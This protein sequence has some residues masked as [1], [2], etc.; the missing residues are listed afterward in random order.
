V[1]S[2]TGKMAP[3]E[4][5]DATSA[6]TSA[7]RTPRDASQSFVGVHS[8][9]RAAI[10]ASEISAGLTTSQAALASEFGVGRTPLREAVRMLQREGLVTSQPNQRVRIAELSSEDVEELYIMRITLETVAIRVT[11]PVLTPRDLAELE[12][13]MAQM[14]HYGMTGDLPGYRVPHGAFHHRLVYAV[15]SRVAAEIAELSDH[16]ERYRQKYGGKWQ[17]RANEHRGI[18]DAAAAGEAD[19]AAELLAAHYLQTV[20]GV[21]KVMDPSH[22]L[23]RLRTVVSVVAP[24]AAKGL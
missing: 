6:D 10:L 17:D 12:G 11:V 13:F 4:G 20:R 2:G 22:D 7:D 21:L 24:G 8:R 1:P 5:R 18:V 19:V 14:A 3:V 15:G 16:S 9:L 23:S